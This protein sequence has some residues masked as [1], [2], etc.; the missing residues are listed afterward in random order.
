MI[1]M[2]LILSLT[3]TFAA[4]ICAQSFFPY[5][6][7]QTTLEN[8]LK[9]ITIPIKNAGLVSYYTI[10]RVGSRDEVEPGKSGFAHFF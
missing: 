4:T 9:V 3:L 2:F 7:E 1:K 8:G 5:K 10:V 6:Y